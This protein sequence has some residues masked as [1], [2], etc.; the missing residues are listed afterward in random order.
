MIIQIDSGFRDYQKYPYN[1]E[2]TISINGQPRSDKNDIRSTNI[3][4]NFIQ[5]AFQWVGN[6]E[7]NNPLSKVPK[8]TFRTKIIPINSNQCFI[9]PENDQ[10]KKLIHT[11]DYFI[12]IQLWI[13]ETNQTS[14]II[15]YDKNL[16]LVTLDQDIFTVFFKDLSFED[17]FNNN[18]IENFSING[19][20]INTSYHEKNN[21]I[22]LGITKT[23]YQPSNKFVISTGAYRGLIVENVTKNWKR[24]IIDIHGIF[25]H[26]LLE[27]IPSYDSNDFFILYQEP[28]LFRNEKKEFFKN[29][30]ETFS[31]LSIKNPP[32]YQEKFKYKDIL[33]EVIKQTPLTIKILHPGNEITE[34]DILLKSMTGNELK[35]RI[36]SIGS[37]FLLKE[38]IT[39]LYELYLLGL[40]DI[41]SNSVEYFTIQKVQD[42]LVYIDYFTYEP[43]FQ[44][45]E[46]IY[47]IP[48]RQVFPNLVIPTIPTQNLICVETQLISLVLP[49][50]PICGYNIYLAD[51]PYVF[52][53]LCNSQGQGCEI[54]ST[55]YS[56]VPS[57]TSNNFV[58][59][60]A[61]IRN[62]RLNFVI[63]NCKQ[64]AI[65]KFSPRDTLQFRVSLPNGQILKYINNKYSKIFDCP[66]LDIPLNLNR[67]RNEKIIYP[68]ILN[69]TISAVF[70][71]RYLF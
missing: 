19:Y 68:Y 10:I 23:N 48:Y 44:S 31:V 26:V 3:T 32:L 53:N 6:S 57:A 59:P 13:E 11:I 29:G 60:I 70:E 27:D 51:I 58:C 71:M 38:D 8:D 37:G 36:Q 25:R 41:S 15:L 64:K 28:T 33:L 24:K 9:I 21:L 20:F 50:L 14:T 2:M 56:N 47:F 40:I 4:E 22:L 30:I 54:N 18:N 55:I 12:G 63:L 65:F 62:P 49:N 39:I 35:I 1:S 66:P 69:N 52:V 7:Q 16:F 5:S 43:L 42:K 46:Y 45:V 34:K 17:C 67:K 61:N